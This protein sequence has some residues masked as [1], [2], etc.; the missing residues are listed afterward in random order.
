MSRVI[1]NK[2]GEIINIKITDASGMKIDSFK[3]NIEDQENIVK[4]VKFMFDKY[5]F[6]YDI[7]KSN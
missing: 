6:D 5:V 7:V 2:G 1:Y 3:S 4:N